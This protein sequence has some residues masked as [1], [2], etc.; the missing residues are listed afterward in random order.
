MHLLFNHF[1]VMLSI[2]FWKKITCNMY[3]KVLHRYAVPSILLLLFFLL[4]MVLNNF[5]CIFEV[6]LVLNF[7]D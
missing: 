4:K 1:Q 3:F 6:V 2:H 5:G 7:C